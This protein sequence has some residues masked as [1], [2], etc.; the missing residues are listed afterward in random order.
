MHFELDITGVIGDLFNLF[1][2]WGVYESSLFILLSKTF[3]SSLFQKFGRLTP[4]LS[5]YFFFNYYFYCQRMLQ[6]VVVSL[7]PPC[8]SFFLKYELYF[9]F[10][11]LPLNLSSLC[12]SY[13][14]K[15]ALTHS[16]VHVLHI[17]LRL[18]PVLL[19]S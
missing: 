19:S 9:I 5:S 15:R 16:F 11:D 14:L 17:G 2:N 10:V 18:K 12:K 13:Q 6:I 7:L 1:A 8:L 3:S 4:P